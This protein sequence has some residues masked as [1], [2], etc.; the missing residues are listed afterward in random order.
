MAGFLTAGSLLQPWVVALKVSAQCNHML[1][2]TQPAVLGKDQEAGPWVTN[3]APVQ[4]VPSNLHH[5]SEV[6]AFHNST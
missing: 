5:R 4:A 1:G 2:L 3:T 6:N